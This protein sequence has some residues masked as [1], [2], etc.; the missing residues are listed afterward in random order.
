T[1]G[2]WMLASCW[3][4]SARHP[5]ST[6]WRP[7]SSDRPWYGGREL[8]STARRPAPRLQEQ[9]EIVAPQERN[10][11]KQGMQDGQKRSRQPTGDRRS[12]RDP[13]E[14]NGQLRKQGLD[15]PFRDAAYVRV[16]GVVVREVIPEDAAPFPQHPR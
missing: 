12:Q 9:T 8:A 6:P 4:R 16:S 1:P 5:G 10:R 11:A 3:R 7:F 13:L 15:L 2:G 14:V